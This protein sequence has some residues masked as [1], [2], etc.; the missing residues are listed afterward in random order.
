MMPVPSPAVPGLACPA[1]VA[2]RGASARFPENTLLAFT[3]AIKAGADMVEIDVRLTADGVP[4]V[5]HDQDVSRTTGGS[6]LVNELTLAE[7]RELSAGRSQ[8][9]R[10]SVPTL[11]DALTL[12]RGQVA[13]QIDIK[14]DPHERGFDATSQHLAEQT[15]QVLEELS[16]P[17][18][19]VSSENP[20]TVDWV[21]RRAPGLATGIEFEGR[22]DLRE[23]LD[24][25]ADRGHAFLLPNAEALLDA[26]RAFID[27]AHALGVQI[28]AWT[29]DDPATMSQ[30]LSWGVDTVETN[31]PAS[32]VPIRD[33][34]R[35]D[36]ARP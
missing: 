5:L 25:S 18:V 4:V 22:A 32:M 12:M 28:D 3:E 36:V 19:I 23:W 21:R 20:R 10:L 24:Y 1:I 15:L 17:S 34:A 33:Q 31:D 30:L 13:V 2:H 6:G 27:H 14:N 26:G 7:V 11:R 29:V 8:Q 35:R 16:F 9:R